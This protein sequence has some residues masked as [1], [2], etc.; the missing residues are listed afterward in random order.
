MKRRII[1]M[2]AISY[3]KMLAL[4]DGTRTCKEVAEET[5]LHYLT[6]CQYTRELHRE[7][8]IHITTWEK[9]SRGRDA[10]RIYK[11]GAGKDAKRHTM[12]QRER[13]ARYRT[14]KAG[15]AFINRVSMGGEV[16]A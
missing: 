16:R 4:I 13:A 3:A 2:G 12:T 15:L 5:G 7:G 11:L 1:K 14:K 8:V 10:I 9:D 6:V